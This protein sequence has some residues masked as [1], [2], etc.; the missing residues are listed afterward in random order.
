ME[1]VSKRDWGMF[2]A[3]VALI[4]IG[5]VFLWVPGLTLVSIA[6]VAGAMLLAVGAFDVYT[7]VRYRQSLDLSGWLIAYA[8]CDIILGIM[9]LVHPIVAAAVI[10]W[11]AGA[12]VVAYGIFEII[13][14]ARLRR[15]ISW[16]WLLLAG[17]VSVLCGVFFFIWPASFALFLGFFLMMRGVTLAVYGV[18]PRTMP[19]DA[20]THHAA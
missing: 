7:Y 3:G 19:S 4:I 1:A 16:G 11:L 17:V 5:F 6:A 13:A 20:A 2:A 8:I 10:P 14:A 9:F 15:A 18:A 12:F